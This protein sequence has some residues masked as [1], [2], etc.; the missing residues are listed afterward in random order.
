[1]RVQRLVGAALVLALLL[2]VS[3]WY[4]FLRHPAVRT[5]TAEFATT[6]GL[7]PGNRVAL[8]G[9]P[10]GDVVDVRPAG[11]VVRVVM[12][13]PTD[14]T[15]PAD[16]EAY[17]MSPDVIS[18]RYVELAPV[19]RGGPALADGAVI[20]TERTH[21]PISWGALT[22][23]VDELVRAV[24]PSAD[25][26][27]GTIAPLLAASAHALD[28]NGTKLRDAITTV[29]QASS[30]LV[31]S[32]PDTLAALDSVS[33]LI[34]ALDRHQGS[35]DRL[36]TSVTQLSQTVDAEQA[37][38]TETVGGLADVL[39]R[40]TDLLQSNGERFTGTVEDLNKVAAT[41]AGLRG[42]VAEILDVA[43]LAFGNV[44]AAVDE[45]D[46][47]RLRASLNASMQQFAAGQAVC[48]ALPTPLCAG[49]GLLNPIP[50]PVPDALDPLGLTQLG[51]G[52]R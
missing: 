29:S 51:G 36:A 27:Q 37:R 42:R 21:S 41:L 35:L 24:G 6:D 49:A 46:T 38:I 16:A 11:P 33:R 43:P 19:Y 18:D 26:P 5:V 2:A 15:V 12:A 32:T 30:V 8:L 40:L 39:T 52:A 48:K 44:A 34:D 1:M 31:G 4:L 50:V 23:A 17:I 9:I 13:L 7:F 45:T 10:V 47:L 14:V 22:E 20:P 28:G 25:D 3:G